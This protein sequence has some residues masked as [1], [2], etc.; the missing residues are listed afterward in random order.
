MNQITDYKKYKKIA[1][2]GG[3][4]NPIHNGH[5]VAAE[6][7]RQQLGVDRVIFIPTGRPPTKTVTLCLTSIG[8]LWL[9]WLLLL[10]LI[11]KYLV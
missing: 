3:T 4:F 1:I 8:I 9:C 5:L 11:L 6:S 2:M 10:T 7:V